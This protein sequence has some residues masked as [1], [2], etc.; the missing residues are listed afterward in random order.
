MTRDRQAQTG[1]KKEKNIYKNGVTVTVQ[2]RT[3][4]PVPP[5]GGTAAGSE[6]NKVWSKSV[7]KMSYRIVKTFFFLSESRQKQDRQESKAGTM[8]GK[9]VLSYGKD[10]CL[11]VRKQAKT[12][13]AGMQCRHKEDKIATIW[14]CFCR[15]LRKV[16]G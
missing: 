3:T 16:F 2:L 5:F 15:I 10:V 4:R 11:F 8:C 9:D 7:V 1:K 13:Q 14:L 6:Q 12:R